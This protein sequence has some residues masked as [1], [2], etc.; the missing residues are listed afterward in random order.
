MKFAFCSRTRVSAGGCVNRRTVL[1]YNQ[2][3]WARQLSPPSLPGSWIE[4]WPAWLELQWGT[5]TCVGWQ[6]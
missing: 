3:C 2:L 6:V 4:C 1:V 5:F